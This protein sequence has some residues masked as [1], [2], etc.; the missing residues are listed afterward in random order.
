MT[1][2]DAQRE[3]AN[4]YSQYGYSPP[5]WLYTGST[6]ITPTRSSTGGSLT[7]VDP[8]QIAQQTA[9]GNLAAAADNTRLAEL[10]NSVNQAAQQSANASRLGPQGQVIQNAL[11][12]NTQRGAAGMIDPST[13]QMLRGRINQLYGSRGMG[14]DSPALSA[15]YLRATGQTV[16]GLEQQ[17]LQNYSQLLAANPA[18]P[19]FNMGELLTPSSTYASAANAEANRQQQAQ[20]FAQN[21]ALQMAELQAQNQRAADQLAYQ[22]A[23]LNQR[24]A[25]GYGSPQS[26]AAYNTRAPATQ[27]G[28]ETNPF[29][30]YTL[31]APSLATGYTTSTPE[32]ATATYDPF[33]YDWS[34]TDFVDPTS[35]LNTYNDWFQ[36]STPDTA[37][38]YDFYTGGEIPVSEYDNYFSGD[39]YGD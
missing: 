33:Q 5:T 29:A 9:A 10:I 6:G 13:E 7:S 11:I 23:A 16:E 3:I 34:P 2:E 8:T 18:A 4:T 12:E 15:A 20:Q 19:I 38:Y 25:G 22:Y 39:D 28:Y 37:S 17:A 1:F 36:T 14:V 27:A 35:Y 30:P 21:Y 26:A 31:V 32:S 24:G